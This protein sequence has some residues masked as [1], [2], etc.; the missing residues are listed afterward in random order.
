MELLRQEC[1]YVIAGVLLA[2]GTDGEAV[3][4]EEL[5][6]RMPQDRRVMA[7]WPERVLHWLGL[8]EA[9]DYTDA[10]RAAR[11]GKLRAVMKHLTDRLY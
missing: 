5:M 9:G 10:A 1:D 3:I 7:V 2:F 6:R 4:Q 8:Y 11:S